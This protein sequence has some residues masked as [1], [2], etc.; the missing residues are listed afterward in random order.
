M[1]YHSVCRKDADYVSALSWAR[2]ISANI[3]R[4][5]NHWPWYNHSAE[6]ATEPD[7]DDP[8][9]DERIENKVFPYR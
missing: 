4:T 7:W 3:T 8:T 6:G 2:E 1:T 5:M 9:G